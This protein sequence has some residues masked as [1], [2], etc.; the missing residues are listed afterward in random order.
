MTPPYSSALLIAKYIFWLIILHHNC[1]PSSEN[2]KSLKEFGQCLLVVVN[3]ISIQTNNS[4]SIKNKIK[5]E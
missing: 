3:I 5:S 1:P 2:D 4:Q